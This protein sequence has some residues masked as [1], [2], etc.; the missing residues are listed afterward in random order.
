MVK[1]SV[2][3]VRSMM[4]RQ[5]QIRNMSVIA[6]VDHGKST[7]ADALIS[8]AGIISEESAGNSRYTQTRKDE[9]TRGITIKSASV[10]LYYEIEHDGKETEPFLI[11]LIDSPGHVDFSSEVTAALRVTDGALVV[12]DC[13][14][15]VC[16]QTETVLRQ[17]I[18][19]RIRPVL[20]VNKLDR[21]FLE[22]HQ[23][24]EQAYQN[25]RNAIE[26]VNVV[27]STYLDEKLGDVQVYPEIGNVAFGSGLQQWGFTLKTFAKIYAPK[28]GMSIEK[29]MKKL[30][31]DN[32]FDKKAKKWVKTSVGSDGSTL[33]RGFCEY[34]ITPISKL[35]SAVMENKV[36]SYTKILE[37][38]EI[39]LPAESKELTGKYLLKAALSTWLPASDCLLDMIIT[40]LPSPIQA[41]KYRVENL[42]SGP[43]EDEAAEAIRTCN[44]E[45]PLMVYVSKMIPTS[46]NGRFYAYGRVFS[47][48]VKTGQTVR[49]L[50]P[51]YVPGKKVDLH[52]KKIQR[53]ALMMGRYVEQISDCPAGNVVGLV[54]IDQYLVKSGTI[55]TLEDA[56]PFV[57]MKFSV[58]PVVRV[59]VEP[60]NPADL[61]KLVEG[62]KRLVKS[63]QMVQ[64]QT[65]NGEH[66][67]A[68]AGALHLEI[69]LK[70]LQDD[71]MNGAEIK[72]SQPVVSFCE[73]VSKPSEIQCVSKSTNKLNRLY[74][75]AEPLDEKICVEIDEGIFKLTDD[76][77]DRARHLA[78]NYGWDSTIARRIWS[79]GCP[80]EGK[81]NILVD[82]TKAAQYVN[83]AKDSI[84]N[85]FQ[86]VSTS[87]VFCGE[88]MRGI[89][90]KLEDVVLHRDSAHRNGNQLISAARRVFY[91]SQIN[92]GP[93]ILEPMY[94]CDITVPTQALSGVYS[95][96]QVR[97][98]EVCKTEERVGTPIVQIQA[99]LPVMESFGFTELLRKNT[100]GQAFPQM[101][102]SHWSQVNGDPFS[103]GS[104]AN[105]IVMDVRKRKG[106]KLEL[107][108]FK[109]Y[110]D[111]I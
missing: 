4:D 10:S 74:V 101:V 96:L 16:V 39:K 13:I 45:G 82:T 27:V 94:L 35:C 33:Q 51:D 77:K 66:I 71:F 80:P 19:E 14:E 12:V 50:G 72:I 107:P 15:G 86:G 34:I 75:T 83:E 78:D 41:Q 91:A 97:R 73:T 81:A 25:F 59:A 26:S 7:L 22:L 42:Y 102:F 70:D 57:T 103:D 38:L 53:T 18:A 44:P 60:K 63:D 110:Y 29:C 100:A 20:F 76:S 9:Q 43:L 52:V 8:K 92:S 111:K 6:H 62:L 85:A 24:P 23:D 2:D 109:E 93:K 58:S 67:V 47:G 37:Q 56:H 69:C 55:T 98:G 104:L 40:H 105:T 65:T 5:S 11:N 48:T 28:W 87:G 106:M 30:W 89:T 61:P 54:G 90:F 95:T 84:I 49:I 3:Q 64:V 32:Y 31:G 68:G 99:Y 88:V 21:V 1:F 79:F 46:E 108:D 17:A 36:D